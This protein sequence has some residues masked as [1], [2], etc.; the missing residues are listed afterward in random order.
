M[1]F[2]LPAE[3]NV[4]LTNVNPRMEKHG[5]ESV[6]AVDLNF[7]MDAPNDVLDQFDPTLLI[8]LY[9]KLEQP[10]QEQA[11]LDGIA[12]VSG[13]PN[14]RFPKLM[15][16]KW[17]WKGAGYTLEIDYGLGRGRSLDLEGV[18]VGKFTI[19]CKEGGTVELKWQCQCV[20]GLTEKILGKLA[21][22]IGQEVKIALRAPTT[23]EETGAKFEPL[24]PNMQKD[25]PLTAEQVFVGTAAADAAAVH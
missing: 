17:D 7:S 10:K 13:F 12:A 20:T 1:S 8:S 9:T 18:E 25:A 2:Q 24:F 5:T 22:M 14:L 3:T 16:I 6:P 11:P 21:L 19:D 15:P 23:L 4:K